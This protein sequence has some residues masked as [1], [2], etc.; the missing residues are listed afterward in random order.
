MRMLDLIHKKNAELELTRKKFS[1]LSRV[2]LMRRFPITR[3]R[4]F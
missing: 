4:L 1:F 2:S 3:Q